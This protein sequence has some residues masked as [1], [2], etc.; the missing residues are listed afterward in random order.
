M[1]NSNKLVIIWSSR[2]R[3]VAEKVTFMYAQGAKQ[4]GWFDEVVLV[5]WGPS[6][7]TL[8]EEEELQSKVRQL[9]KADITVRACSVCAKE[10]GV[11]EELTN[12]GLDVSPMGP[13]ITRYLKEGWKMLTF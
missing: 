3:D 5:V 4:Q 13:E 8:A 11:A 6:T 9:M 12:L 2:D 10:Y 7:K 1:D